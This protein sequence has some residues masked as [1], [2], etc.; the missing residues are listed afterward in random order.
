MIQEAYQSNL[1]WDD[2]VRST[3]VLK[4]RRL[5]QQLSNFDPFILSRNYLD[6]RE[7]CTMLGNVSIIYIFNV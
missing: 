2:V 4:W 6:K 5:I 1:N 7:L 3:L